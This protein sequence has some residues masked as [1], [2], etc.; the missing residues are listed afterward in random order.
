MH[1]ACEAGICADLPSRRLRGADALRAPFFLFIPLR[2]RDLCAT[3]SASRVCGRGAREPVTDH[4]G[5]IMRLVFPVAG[6]P[7]TKLPRRSASASTP[8]AVPLPRGH[9]WGLFCR[10]A[11]MSVCHRLAQRLA[12]IDRRGGAK[13][14]CGRAR[15]QKM[16]RPPAL[17]RVKEQP[18]CDHQEGSALGC[19]RNPESLCFSPPPPSIPALPAPLWS[20]TSFCAPAPL[21]SLQSDV[22]GSKTPC[23]FWLAEPHLSSLGPPARGTGGGPAARRQRGATFRPLS[24][25][26]S[27]SSCVALFQNLKPHSRPQEWPRRKHSF[28]YWRSSSA[29][30]IHRS[31]QISPTVRKRRGRPSNME[32]S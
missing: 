17:S 25:C 16:T 1:G 9:S 28:F 32:P 2:V 13:L 14:D 15:A 7:R 18:R 20:Q 23:V 30:R 5:S 4:R 10:A 6:E 22:S 21:R 3:T 8:L 11:I 26:F 19:G 31:L 27:L 29:G 24:S 12:G